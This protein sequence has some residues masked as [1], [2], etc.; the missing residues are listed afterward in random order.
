MVINPNYSDDYLFIFTDKIDNFLREFRDRNR[1]TLVYIGCGTDFCPVHHLREVK[2]FIYID[3]QPKSEF[4]WKEYET[5]YFFREKYMSKFA[6]KVPKDFLKA[7]NSYPD[8]YFNPLTKQK[9]YHYYNLPFPLTEKVYNFFPKEVIEGLEFFLRRATHLVA[10]GYHPHVE[11][12]DFL[13]SQF[14]LVTDE[15]TVYPLK[16][17]S[18]DYPTIFSQLIENQTRIEEIKHLTKKGVRTFASYD[19][20]LQSGRDKKIKLFFL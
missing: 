18:E 20:L 13:P 7:K 19:E 11:I 6:S 8:I 17:D 1:M 10:C 5:G 3:C 15:R 2:D 9:I 14:I 16:K 4:G 12:L